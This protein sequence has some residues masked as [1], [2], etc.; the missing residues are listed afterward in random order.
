MHFRV[1]GDREH[2]S[3]HRDTIRHI[4][5]LID[6]RFLNIDRPHQ[7]PKSDRTRHNFDKITAPAPAGLKDFA[8]LSIARHRS[9]TITEPKSLKLKKIRNR[10]ALSMIQQL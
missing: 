6:V 8:D 2:L 7:D 1:S 3:S 9:L 4:T 10:Q 5:T